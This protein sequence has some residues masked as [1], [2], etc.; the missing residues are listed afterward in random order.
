MKSS[1]EYAIQNTY[2]LASILIC[3]CECVWSECRE[4]QVHKCKGQALHRNRIQLFAAK[5][6]NDLIDQLKHERIQYPSIH[7][8]NL[9][10]FHTQ[11]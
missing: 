6:P 5:Q 2:R 8:L 9:S 11:Q 7:M 4:M 3:G 10:Y 1:S